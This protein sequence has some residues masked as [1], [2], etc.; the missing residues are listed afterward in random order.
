[1]TFC[2]FSDLGAS[3]FIVAFSAALAGWLLLGVDIVF[4]KV[5]STGNID[6]AE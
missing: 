2:R 5:V 6:G 3:A 1:M 4:T